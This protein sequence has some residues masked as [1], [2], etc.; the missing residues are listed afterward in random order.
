VDLVGQASK[1]ADLTDTGLPGGSADTIT[2]FVAQR[3]G[4][5]N[6]AFDDEVFEDEF[7]VEEADAGEG[8]AGEVLECEHDGDRIAP[9]E[10]V[11]RIRARYRRFG[12]YE[13]AFLAPSL[14]R[15]ALLSH[16]SGEARREAKRAL[17]ELRDLER[18]IEVV[19]VPVVAED[20]QGSKVRL[21]GDALR[22]VADVWRVRRA[23]ARG[24]YDETPVRDPA[25]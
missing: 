18:G 16:F 23:A 10:V 25:G 4:R 21:G 24:V 20:R 3:L 7:A 22:M 2:R 6:V 13:T 5:V 11:L 12:L 9:K 19:E 8:D 1:Q 17:S 15:A 14:D